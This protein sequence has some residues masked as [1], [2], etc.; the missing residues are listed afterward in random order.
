MGASLLLYSKLLL[1]L[2]TPQLACLVIAL[3]VG[4]LPHPLAVASCLLLATITVVPVRRPFTK[5]Q[6]WLARTLS[7]T[8]NAYFPMTMHLEEPACFEDTA[9]KFLIGLEPHSVLPVSV[10]A[11]FDGGALPPSLEARPRA[12]LASSAIFRV[13]LVR[14]LWSWLGL[15][16]VDRRTLR[17]LLEEGNI[18]I[19]IPGGV[20]ECMHLAPGRET[21]YLKRRAGFAKMALQHGAA[22]IPAFAFGQSNIFG[23]AAPPRP[24]AVAFARLAGFAPIV[25]W[26]LWGTPIPRRVP[27]HVVLGKPIPVP[28]VAEPSSEQVMALL[29]TFI[30]EMERLFEAHKAAAGY[31]ELELVVL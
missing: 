25:Y 9:R 5:A 16:S 15:Q 29:G 13:P 4:C 11:F 24:V 30:K 19:L 28:L 27:I 23:F 12:A 21:V 3:C 17:R 31:P 8:A 7:D 26:G 18:P 20:A 14:H 1:W 6:M 10:V 2:G 22:L